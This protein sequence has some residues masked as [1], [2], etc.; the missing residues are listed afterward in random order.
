MDRRVGAELEG[1]QA[2][3]G[4]SAVFA[5]AVQGR[6]RRHREPNQRPV[7]EDR[8]GEAEDPAQRGEDEQAPV[9][10]READV[11]SS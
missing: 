11:M 4:G 6:A 3:A 10:A 5:G 7:G 8:L 9:L 1:L 2:S